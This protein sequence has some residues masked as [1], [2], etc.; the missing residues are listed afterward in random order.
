MIPVRTLDAI[1]GALTAL[2]V[3]EQEARF[4]PRA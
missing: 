4:V 2:D 1:A 3:R